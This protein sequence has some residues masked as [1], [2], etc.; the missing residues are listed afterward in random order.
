MQ[1][2][3]KA[4]QGFTLIELLIVVAIIGILAAIA[5][6]AYQNYTVKAKVSEAFSLLDGQKAAVAIAWHE[7]G[8]P[9]TGQLTGTGTS[10]TYVERIDVTSNSP[11]LILS[12]DIRATGNADADAGSVCVSSTDGSVWTCGVSSAAMTP[13]VSSSCSG[14]MA[15]CN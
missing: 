1:V 12:A 14:V 5:I 7:T 13:F 10:A 8:L 15:N 4:Q 3:R 6:P 9:A 11:S 2:I